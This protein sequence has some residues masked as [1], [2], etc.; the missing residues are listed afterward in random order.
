MHSSLGETIREARIRAGLGLRELA[1]KLK[2][3]TP[4]YLSDIEN[5]R[6]IPSEEVLR[7]IASALNLDFDGLMALAGRIG[8]DALR[9]LQRE[10]AAGALFRTVSEGRLDAKALADLSERAEK[11]AKAKRRSEK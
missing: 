1:R 4:S 9:Y 5:D 7:G 8:D 10:P 6:R 3:V 2:S 11:L